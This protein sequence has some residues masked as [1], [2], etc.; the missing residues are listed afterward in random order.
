MA[1][2]PDFREPG[3]RKSPSG[4][5]G[6]SPGGGLERNPQQQKLSFNMLF[7][8]KFSA[9]QCGKRI[10]KIIQQLYKL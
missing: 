8:E 1:G 7:N 10:M 5:Q 6:H 3:G 9:K 4:V 2:G